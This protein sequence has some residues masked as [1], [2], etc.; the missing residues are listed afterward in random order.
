[1][2]S[3]RCQ[4]DADA[5]GG[6]WFDAS[7]HL[8]LYQNSGAIFE[9]DVETLQIVDMQSGPSSSRNDGAACIESADL[10]SDSG[11]SDGAGQ[12][13]GELRYVLKE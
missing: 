3:R 6:A 5:F 12:N 10:E 11:E 1:M 7:G 9:I 8:F 13:V 4:V 2:I